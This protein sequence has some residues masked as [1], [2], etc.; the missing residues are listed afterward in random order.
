MSL[1]P[2]ADALPLTTRALLL[3]MDGTLI[4]SGPTVERA[5]DSLLAELGSTETFG[6]AM[7]GVPA[8]VVLT[9][10]FPE[11]DEQEIAAAHA[12]IEQ[13]EIEDVDE[14]VTMPG[15]ARILEQLDDAAQQLGRATWTIVTSCTRPLFEARWG[16]TGLPAPEALVTA[17]QVPR[18]KPDPDPYL[19][20]AERLG[21]APADA[22]VI[23]DSAGGLRSGAAAGCTTIAVT[24]TTPAADLRPLAGALVT[25]LDDLEVTVR[26]DALLISRRGQA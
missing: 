16:T 11:M 24:S 8:R 17:D 6:P 13:I 23:E 25:S 3:D 19:L 5:W 18:G 14:I 4:D 22:V 10:L 20:G 2:A 1:D 21:V 15:T 12:R 7:H 9:R 26:E